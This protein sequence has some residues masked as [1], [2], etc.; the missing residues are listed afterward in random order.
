[1]KYI[2]LFENF[3]RYDF[4]DHGQE[5]YEEMRKNIQYFPEDQLSYITSLLTENG[6][7]YET[8]DI[9]SKVGEINNEINF[10]IL[11]SEDFL[12][13]L[14]YLGD[15]C[16]GIYCYET[17]SEEFIKFVIV[18]DIDQIIP[19]IKTIFDELSINENLASHDRSDFG[20]FPLYY[21][22]GQACG[23]MIKMGGTRVSKDEFNQIK[24][25][26]DGINSV[27]KVSYNDQNGLSII[28]HYKKYRHSSATYEDLLDYE[29]HSKEII[30]YY[31]GDYCY[32]I[33]YYIDYK[34]YILDQFD[35]VL[36]KLSELLGVE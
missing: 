18:E 2:K 8:G 10:I 15:Y 25:L 31:L 11:G 22:P 16:Y 21:R 13:E 4:G 29:I 7:E 17:G 6:Y 26:C 19:I 14:F 36:E 28:Q 34:Y 30:I 9:Y 23:Y 32:G 3:D 27:K 35:S 12:I 5:N 20:E 24:E 1:M 33:I